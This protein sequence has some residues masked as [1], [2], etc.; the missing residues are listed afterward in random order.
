AMLSLFSL[1]LLVVFP[2]LSAMDESAGSSPGNMRNCL[3]CEVPINEVHM[4]IDACRACSVFYKRTLK[5]NKEW[6]KCKSGTEDCIELKPTTSCR[7]CR[8]RKFS[9]VLAQSS[10]PIN[11]KDDIES[12]TDLSSQPSTS[13]LDHDSFSLIPISPSETPLL[14]RLKNGYSFVCV[15]RKTGEVPLIPHDFKPT[16]EMIENNDM[17]FFAM[18]YPLIIPTAQVHV[19]AL[20]DFGNAIFD[21]FRTLSNHEKL[22]MVMASFKVIVLL[23]TAYRSVHYFPDCDT[24]LASYMFT[25]NDEGTEAFLDTCPIEINKEELAREFQSNSKKLTKMKEHLQLLAPTDFEFALLYGLS[26]WSNEVSLA[27]EDKT[28]M[29]EKNRKSIMDELHTMYKQQG[30]HDYAARLGELMCLLTNIEE[31]CRLAQVDLELYK[32]MNIFNF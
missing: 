8:F 28:I 16:P 14:D 21:D 13:F 7:K 2:T 1:R 22:E 25:A 12:D 17:H 29:V 3:I 10:H 26:F 4:G 6:L 32:L 19:T 24:R 23:D 5:L 15:V 30:R 20:F 9:E 18:T 27:C 31:I 11:V